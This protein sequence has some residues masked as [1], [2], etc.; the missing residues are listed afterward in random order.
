MPPFI[1]SPLCR[2]T[3][4]VSEYRVPQVLDTILLQYTLVLIL[5]RYVI[6]YLVIPPVSLL[7]STIL[8]NIN[9]HHTRIWSR[10]GFF[11]FCFVE[12]QC[13]QLKISHLWRW[14]RSKFDGYRVANWEHRGRVWQTCMEKICFGE[15]FVRGSV[16]RLVRVE[17]NNR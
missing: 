14:Y 13:K 3:H 6:R 7:L 15:M 9:I 2:D 1:T 5:T 17:P 12:R 4:C 10:G 16:S 8:V 11:L